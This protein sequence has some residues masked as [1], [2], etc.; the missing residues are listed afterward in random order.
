MLWHYICSLC[1]P[2]E[3]P[4]ITWGQGK[5]ER[6]RMREREWEREAERDRNRGQANE[7]LIKML[8]QITSEGNLFI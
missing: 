2:S 6:D 7:I 4:R 1:Y 5:K 3:C 8:G